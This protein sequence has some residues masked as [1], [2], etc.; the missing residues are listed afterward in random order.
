M[1]TT[2]I[3]KIKNR[4]DNV[5]DYVSNK[6]KT[7][8][9][10]YVSGLNCL[11]ET[12]FKEMSIVKKQYNKTNGILGFHAYQSFKGYEVTSNEAHEIGIRL[13]E[14]LWGNRFQV[15]VAT[16]TNTKNVHNHFFINSVSFVDGKDNKVNYAIMRRTSDNICKEYELQT[17][18]EKSFYKN[19]SNRY[20]RSSKYLECIRVDIDYA[21][22][23]ASI[24]NDFTKILTKMG[25]ELN[26]EHNKMSIRKPPY[27]RYTRVEKTFG[28]EYSRESILFRIKHTQA[29][30]VP[31]LECHTLTGRYKRKNK[32]SIRNK[33][34]AKGL[35]ALYYYY[36]YLLK[37]FPKQKYP[38]KYSKAMK[39]EIKKMDNYSNSA[40]FL[41]KY[42]ITTLTEIK[43]YK[44]SAINKIVELKGLRENLWRKH[45]RIKTDEEGQFICSEIQKLATKIDELNKDI[46]LCNFIEDNTLK[47]K[48][49]IKEISE[50]EHNIKVK[51]KNRYER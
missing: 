12:A 9:K 42:N 23:Q 25:Y 16:H 49:S 41:V 39:E 34:K 13:A 48:N 5:I 35:R 17:L 14:E 29:F 31:F 1:A 10:K 37:V 45:K 22:S 44:S 24:Y 6:D 26:H 51:N 32:T 15:I 28:E 4:F 8:N 20:A 19:I 46:K 21:I 33:L 40:R 27:K 18:E 43:E 7:D 36:C 2:K 30:K 38:P 3:W 11:P 47:M 50:E